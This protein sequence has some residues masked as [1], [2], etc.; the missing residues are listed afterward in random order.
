MATAAISILVP[1]GG[2][3]MNSHSWVPRPAMRSAT[4]SP[5][6]MISSIVQRRSRKPDYIMARPFLEASSPVP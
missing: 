4:V 3:P 5:S 1:V 2:T 6:A